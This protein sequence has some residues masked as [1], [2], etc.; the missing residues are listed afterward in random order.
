MSK[1][2]YSN[3]NQ[4][5]ENSAVKKISFIFWI[6]FLLVFIGG[7]FGALIYKTSFTFSKIKFS[8]GQAGLLPI[9]DIIPEDDKDR[10]NILLLGY[11]GEG[12]PNGG[13][14]TDTIIVLSI[15]KSTGQVALISVPRDLYIKIPG[16]AMTE[17]INYAYAHGEESGG[18]GLLYARAAISYVT[19]LFIDKVVLANFNAFYELIEVLDGIDVYLDEPFK[20]DSQFAKEKII[21]LPSGQNHLDAETALYYVR[22]RYSTNDFDRARRQQQVLL[23]V[24]DKAL[25]LGVLTNPFKLFDILDIL[26]NN[27]K[28]DLSLGD[29]KNLISIYDEINFK[30]LRKKIFDTTPQGLL[31]ADKN[32]NGAYILK[33]VGDNFDQIKEV[34]KNIFD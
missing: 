26:G 22:S 17:K 13:L 5:Q 14:L 18:Q 21:D 32:E 30:D 1:D 19:G 4:G 3:V 28:T 12:D 16:T 23:A 15:K 27:V 11:R 31:Y 8:N 25:T 33:P 24:K 20:E 34:A 29:I 7:I 10:E 9:H 6:L 2:N